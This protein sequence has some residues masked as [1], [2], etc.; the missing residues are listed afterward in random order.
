ME[1]TTESQLSTVFIDHTLDVIFIPAFIYAFRD[2]KRALFLLFAFVR[3]VAF[4]RNEL[5]LRT[6]ERNVVPETSIFS[7]S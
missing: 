6:I 4:V 7:S 2:L 1:T 3:L 5:G